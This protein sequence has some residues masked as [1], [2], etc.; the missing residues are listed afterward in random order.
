M[1]PAH[2][3]TAREW[4]D[5]GWLV[6]VLEDWLLIAE[7]ATVLELAAFLRSISSA[8]TTGEVIVLLG[9][10]RALVTSPCASD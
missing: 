5:L 10:L 7:P 1:S 3:L 6:A 4:Q 2:T 8:A 9:E